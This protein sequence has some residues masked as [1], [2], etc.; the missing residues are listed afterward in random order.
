MCTVQSTYIRKTHM[1][2]MKQSMFRGCCT[3]AITA[4]PSLNSSESA[5][6]VG[7]R[8]LQCPHLQNEF[9][10]CKDTHV[11]IYGLYHG[12][13]NLTNTGVSDCIVCEKLSCVNSRGSLV[14]RA[15]TTANSKT[16][17]AAAI[18]EVFTPQM[19]WDGPGVTSRGI[20]SRRVRIPKG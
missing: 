13:K 6:H 12:A 1:L 8:R 20:W 15:T 14:A 18:L 10:Q 2:E 16:R 4:D 9:K 11:W 5:S 19:I 7:A 3:L 17:V